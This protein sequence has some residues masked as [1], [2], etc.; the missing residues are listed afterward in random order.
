MEKA[1]VVAL[2]AAVIPQLEHS[3]C[4]QLLWFE[5]K[6]SYHVRCVVL[7]K[8]GSAVSSNQRVICAAG[9]QH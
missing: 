6:L 4:S 7:V 8:L 2:V 9:L 5:T 3:F 1:A